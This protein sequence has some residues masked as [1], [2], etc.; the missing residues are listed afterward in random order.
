L[1]IRDVRGL[2]AHLARLGAG[3]AEALGEESRLRV[4]VNQR[5]AGFDAAIGDGDEVAFFPPVTGG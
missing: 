4:A 3:Y 1:N 2:A 5:H